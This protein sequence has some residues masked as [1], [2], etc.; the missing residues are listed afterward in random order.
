MKRLLSCVFFLA[1]CSSTVGLA[2][3]PIKLGFLYI[4]SGRAAV[5]GAVSQQG[6]QLAID[7]INASG[8]LLGREVKGFF[9]DTKGKPDIGEAEAR[10]LVSE[11]KV[12]AV[13]G[14]ISS[15]VVPSVS[16][17]MNELQTPLIITNA[18]NP[19][20]TGSACNRYTFRTAYDSYQQLRAAAILATKTGAKKWTT[21]G[22]DYSL[23]LSSW[24][25]FRKFLRELDPTARF[26]SDS[27]V[28][29]VPMSTTDWTKVIEKVKKS[30]AD[31]ILV[32]LWGGNFIDFVRQG[33]A[34][35][36]F[37]G[38]RQALTQTAGMAECS[39]LGKDLPAGFWITNSY[40][41]EAY[42]NETNTKFV[43]SYSGKYGALPGFPSHWAYV[44]VK[45]YAEAVRKAGSTDKTAVSKAL[46]GLQISAP[47]G[48][49]T[50]RPED[51]QAIFDMA[52]GR[53][54][55][56]VIIHKGK[57]RTQI[58][59]ALDPVFLFPADQVALPLTQ[60]HCRMP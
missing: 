40:L 11:E 31:G 32:S 19:T 30:G 57:H 6:A 3:E 47:V 51:H 33:V 45:C 1:I 18:S 34:A 24:T 55:E 25:L 42:K 7:E 56:K 17:A 27:E 36:L 21:V 43:N 16:T 60:S 59:R 58:L 23:G 12:D 52:G 49:V 14:V 44:G 8:G 26:V 2:A 35:G 20:V 41:T 13:L 54:S 28:V 22:P 53:V 10:K 46:E 29:F 48:T 50:I 15:A 4:L 9:R 5:F 38:N 39:V 37:K